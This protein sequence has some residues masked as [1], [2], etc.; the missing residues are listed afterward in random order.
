MDD[1]QT[2]EPHDFDADMILYA[3]GA[4]R[5]ALLIIGT[6]SLVVGI[7]GI[8]LP[9]LPTTPFLLISAACYA[10]SSKKFYVWLLSNRWFGQYIRDWRAGKGIPLS[11]KI[12]ATALIVATFGTS[13]VFFV[14]IDWV[15]VMMVGIALAVVTYLWRLP[16]RL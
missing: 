3:S 14:P 4:A 10:R 16:T 11:A 2:S 13:I 9:L 5:W 1:E 15:K 7:I 6:I 8:V 12:T